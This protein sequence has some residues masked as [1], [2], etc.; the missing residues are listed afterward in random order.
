MA[1]VNLSRL[2]HHECAKCGSAILALPR[3]DMACEQCGCTL[4]RVRRPTTEE[5]GY[6]VEEYIKEEEQERAREKQDMATSLAIGVALTAVLAGL[7]ILLW[8]KPIFWMWVAFGFVI[9]VIYGA[10]ASVFR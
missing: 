8:D 3:R 2:K 7:V 9:I 6:F 5:E 4:F 1:S 10:F